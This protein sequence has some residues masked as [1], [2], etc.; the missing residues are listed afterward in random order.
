M[1]F[2]TSQQ[3]ILASANLVEV[4]Q[5]IRIFNCLVDPVNQSG[6]GFNIA[7]AVF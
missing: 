5:Q 4:T 3:R 6:D 7:F 1:F 2:E